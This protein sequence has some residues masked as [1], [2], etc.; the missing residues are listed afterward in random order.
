MA[1]TSCYPSKELRLCNHPC[2]GWG[3]ACPMSPI[4]QARGNPG[5]GH[6]LGRSPEKP[7]FAFLLVN[8]QAEECGVTT[9][10]A[11]WGVSCAWRDTGM[12]PFGCAIYFLNI[13]GRK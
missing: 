7:I 10:T 9:C 6:G 12:S 1:G 13:C 4:P 3:P 2:Q 5:H 8:P 11:P